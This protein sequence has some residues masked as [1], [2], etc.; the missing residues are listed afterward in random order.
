MT[1]L[2]LKITNTSQILVFRVRSRHLSFAPFSVF[3]ASQDTSAVSA[4]VSAQSFVLTALRGNPHSAWRECGRGNHS[5]AGDSK[6]LCRQGS[7]EFPHTCTHTPRLNEHTHAGSI[8]Y[9]LIRSRKTSQTDAENVS[10]RR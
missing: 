4:S 3:F 9:S 1:F 6:L 2:L 8:T 7:T 10:Q 5:R